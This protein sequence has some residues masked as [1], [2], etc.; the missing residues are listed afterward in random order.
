MHLSPNFRIEELAC[1]CGCKGEQAP[2]I[3]AKLTRLCVDVLEPL[4]SLC[5][6]PVRI[7][8]GYRCAAHNA[9]VGGEPASKHMRG[10]AADTQIDGLKPS[11]VAVFARTIKGLGGLGVY[12][13]WVHVDVRDRVA[14]R[15]ETWQG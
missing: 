2:E 6:S 10:E 1:S 7:T 4:R 3:R 15:L 9:K 13:R 8:S 14:G 5:G 12:A 11:Q